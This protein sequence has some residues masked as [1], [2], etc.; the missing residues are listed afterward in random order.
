MSEL[1]ERKQTNKCEADQRDD[2]MQGPLLQPCIQVRAP[3]R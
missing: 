2:V 1:R 3:E